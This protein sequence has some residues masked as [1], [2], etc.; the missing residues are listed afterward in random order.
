MANKILKTLTLPSADGQ[1][2]TY[3]LHPEWDN[4][5]NKNYEY[6]VQASFVND[7]NLTSKTDITLID[8]NWESLIQAIQENKRVICRMIDE[9]SLVYTDFLFTEYTKGPPRVHFVCSG[10]GY[11]ENFFIYSNGDIS[12]GKRKTYTD[13]LLTEGDVPAEAKATGDA[14]NQKLS[15]ATTEGTGEA[16]TVTIP[17]AGPIT[18]GFTFIMIPHTDST[19]I[20]LSLTVNGIRGSLVRTDNRQ[21]GYYTASHEA[22]LQANHAYLV[23]RGGAGG[24]MWLVNNS[25]INPDDI[26]G[27]VAIEH[28]GTG[29]TTATG[30]LANLG[31]E[32]NKNLLDNWYF[33]NPKNTTGSEYYY[34]AG[35]TIDGWRLSLTDASNPF[36]WVSGSS[37]CLHHE[38]AQD[39]QCSCFITQP[40]GNLA[41]LAGKTVTFSVMFGDVWVSGETRIGIR[42]N[43]SSAYKYA[44][45]TEDNQNGILS[46]TA[47]LP[48][49]I[50]SLDVFIGTMKGSAGKGMC[51][52]HLISAKLELGAISTLANDAPPRDSD[53]IV[54]SAEKTGHY[55][56][57]ISGMKE[58]INPPMVLD[59]EY[60]IA[61]RW[62]NKVCYCKWLSVGAMPNASAKTVS[63]PDAVAVYHIDGFISRDSKYYISVLTPN[64]SIDNIYFSKSEHLISLHTTA[65]MSTWKGYLFVKYVK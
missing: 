64:S 9:D 28:G 35:Q 19:S 21:G 63:L 51:T 52:L 41:L 29:A 39:T 12:Y 58:W 53:R 47:T 38:T 45:V 25:K 50:S 10:N 3:E 57:M 4:I 40:V 2:I 26:I 33:A 18:E 59:T 16:Y 20:S 54:E 23:T 27:T 42:C 46:V 30:A 65:D 1:S 31:A 56:R 7:G 60:R 14:L 55:Y 36:V 13:S 43:S 62:N 24:T 37:T 22:W 11:I 15:I 49:E 6:I 61:E 32:P 17:N 5:E 8:F 34:A 44:S 48:S